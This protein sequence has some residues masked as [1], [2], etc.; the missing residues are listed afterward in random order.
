MVYSFDLPLL[1][2]ISEPGE[3]SKLDLMVQ[4]D[5]TLTDYSLKY[6]EQVF[7]KNQIY[8]PLL[9]WVRGKADILQASAIISN[10]NDTILL[11][12]LF[13]LTN[14]ISQILGQGFMFQY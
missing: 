12:S 8:G 5:T 4:L 13:C 14:Q 3:L 11:E 7:T 2:K 10:I 9:I 1:D 6:F